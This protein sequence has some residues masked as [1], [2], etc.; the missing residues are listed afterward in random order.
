MFRIGLALRVARSSAGEYGKVGRIGMALGTKSPDSLM[1]PGIDREIESVMVEGGWYPGCRSVAH[2]TGS[3]E[4]CSDMV[5]IGCAVIVGHMATIAGIGCT[6]IIA[7]MA[8]IA[9]DVDMGAC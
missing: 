7:V 5:R 9:I 8:G 4:P 6:V 3:G 2:L 1:R